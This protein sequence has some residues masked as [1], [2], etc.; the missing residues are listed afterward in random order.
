MTQPVPV[1]PA[2]DLAACD[3]E[4]IRTPGSIQPQGFLLTLSPE[5]HILQASENL[6]EWT[7]TAAAAAVGQGLAAVIGAAAAERLAAELAPDKLGARPLY[8]GTVTVG[9]GQA[10]RC[11]RTC[12]GRRADRRI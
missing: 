3:K 5:H 2:L 10:F 9:N 8:L 11:A 7:G 12:L 4:P 6:G 1:I